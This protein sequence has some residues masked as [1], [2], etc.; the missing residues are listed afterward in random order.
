M[1]TKELWKGFWQLAILIYCSNETIMHLFQYW[2]EICST[3]HSKIW[4]KYGQISPDH[5]E[6]KKI[7]PSFGLLFITFYYFSPVV[8]CTHISFQTNHELG[9]LWTT[10]G[11]RTRNPR[12][13]LH[14]T[15]DIFEVDRHR[16]PMPYPLGHG[17]WLDGNVVKLAEIPCLMA[18]GRHK[19]GFPPLRK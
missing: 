6:K 12:L 3:K 11:T 16:R 19:R 15:S 18:S 10:G 14:S 5:V 9:K 2:N 4:T 1:Y 13:T 7:P 17:G 8:I